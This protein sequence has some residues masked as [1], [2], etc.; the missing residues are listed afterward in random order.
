MNSYQ[1]FELNDQEF[2][3][4]R[5]LVYNK[6]GINLTEKKRGLVRGR[7]NKYL[8][9]KGHESFEDY[10]DTLRKDES[11]NELVELINRLS[12]NHTFFFRESEHFEFLNS[13]LFPSLE[14]SFKGDRELR[15][16]CAGCASG[17]EAYTLAITASE[18]F[19]QSKKSF[20]ILATD[21]STKALNKA[22]E[23]VYPWERV[24]K[25]PPRL[26]SKYF[27]KKNQDSYVVSESLRDRILFRRLNFL[28]D[29]YPFKN[30]FSY[31]LLQKCHDIFR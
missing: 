17:E 14:E 28:Q 11:G 7:L 13:E 5:E 21:I 19:Q 26:L 29:E 2:N 24:S 1:F 12:T 18:Y 10:L 20:K 8:N 27:A 3:E 16:W 15:F 9:Q 31:D 4:I 22:L 23:G 6:V 30:Q 25:V